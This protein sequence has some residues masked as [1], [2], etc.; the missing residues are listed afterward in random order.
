MPI[1]HRQRRGAHEPDGQLPRRRPGRSGSGRSGEVRAK[2][3][4]VLLTPQ[5]DKIVGDNVQLTDTLARRHDR[6]SDCRAGK[7]RPDR[8]AARN[9]GQWRHPPSATRSIHRARLPRDRLPEAAELGDHRGTGDRRSQ[10]QPH[11]LRRG[12]AAAVRDRSCRCCRSSISPAA[13]KERPAGWSLTCGL[14]PQRR[15]RSASPYHWQIGRNRDATITPARLHQ[16]SARDRM[17]NIAN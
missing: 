16:R 5:G 17:S 15:S 12:A 14:E 11:P 1:G 7:R 2:G 3:N 9:A 10:G 4:V 8:R 13:M 6:Q